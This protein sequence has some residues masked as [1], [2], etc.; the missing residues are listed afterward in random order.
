MIQKAELDMLPRLKRIWQTCFEDDK[1]YVDFVF[2]N[3]LGPAQMLVETDENG[4]PIAMVNWKLL[5]FTTPRQSFTGAYIFGV[6][7]LPQHRGKGI[8]SGLMEKAHELLRQDGAQLSCLI[9][10]GKNLFDFYA[11]KGF[12]TRFHYKSLRVGG[13]EIPKTSRQGVLSAAALEDLY[14]KRAD[15][16]SSR[17][18]F[19]AWDT[20]YLRYVTKECRFY[21]GEV[22][23]FS[24]GG[25]QGYAVCH[26]MRDGTLLVKE[27]VVD[28]K[29]V[30]IL[31]AALDARY[32]AKNYHLR[33]PGDFALENKW[34][35]EI[36]PFAMVK[37][38]NKHS[39]NIPIGGAP[40]FAFGLDS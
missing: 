26:P 12:E 10:A 29:D 35:A 36:L 13:E 9:P 30:D 23:R 14:A 37:W 38:Y 20:N 17:S 22:L 3:L 2:G 15:S 34:G 16:F 27:A 33:L 11:A 24:C 8:S 39:A 40:W 25:N 21:R 5:R 7:T 28:P 18:L 4:R 1:N 32:K 19:G 6:C 31:L